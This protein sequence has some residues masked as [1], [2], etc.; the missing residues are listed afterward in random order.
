MP[1]QKGDVHKLTEGRRRFA[2]EY[3]KS[4]NA[5]EA[6]LLSFDTDNRNTASN[7]ASNLLDDPRVQALVE[8]ERR[9]V[10][11]QTKVD[12]VRVFRELAA[13]AFSDV[14]ELF[15]E[16]DGTLR[17]PRDWDSC[18]AAAVS[19]IEVFERYQGEGEKKK[20]V[21]RIKKVRFWDKV[22]S[23]EKI[24]RLLGM[25]FK[26]KPD[27]NQAPPVNVNVQI[28]A[29]KRLEALPVDVL[30]KFL[31]HL[32]SPRPVIDAPESVGRLGGD[33]EAGP[34]PE[35]LPALRS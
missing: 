24:A 5:T 10:M 14:R 11:R 19:S 35:S 33:G 17:D 32:R 22:S 2:I 12:S 16:E 29:E 3:V 18:T 31:E 4:G 26:D 15:N 25:D 8:Q 7:G 27:L 28:N 20:Y 9:R 23:L 6:Y 34:M 13:L 1:K 30:E 21:G